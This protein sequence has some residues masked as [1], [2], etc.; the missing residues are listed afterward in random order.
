[1]IE[2]ELCGDVQIYRASPDPLHYSMHGGGIPSGVQ[3]YAMTLS[4]APVEATF[5]PEAFGNIWVDD[6]NPS[7]KAM[8]RNRGREPRKV[9]LSLET[10]S[11]DGREKT[12][13]KQ[14]FELHGGESVTTRFDLA[15]RR[16]GWHDVVLKYG[17]QVHRRSLVI[18]RR[19]EQTPRPFDTRG[20]MFGIWSPGR[21]HYTLSPYDTFRLAGPLGIE[22]ISH[23][24]S[25]LAEPEI[26]ALPFGLKNFEVAKIGSRPR[27][28]DVP[29]LAEKLRDARIA[30]S[31]VSEP[32]FQYLFAEPGGIGSIG[33]LPEFYGEP[34][35]QRTPQEEER[36]VDFKRMVTNFSHHFRAQYP[37]K[38]IL[39][40]WGNP[41]FAIP[42]LQDPATREAFD[43]VGF[44]TAFFD[45]LPEMQAHQCS[46]H[47]MMLQFNHY[48]YTYRK[49]PPLVVTVEGPCLG[50]VK[51]GALT[52]DQ[53]AAHLPRA[54]LTLMPYGI[55]RFFASVSGGPENCS[56]WGEQ[57]YGGGAFT[58]VTLDPYPA[59]ATQGTLIRHL[60]HME[61]VKAVPTGS[62]STFCYQFKD[63][64][65]NSLLH[66]LW[67]IRGRR[68]VKMSK[69]E[70][71]DSMDNL[72]SG[73]LVLDQLPVYVYGCDGTLE[74]GEPDHRD[75]QLA[76]DRVELGA[77]AD[78]FARQTQE[79]DAEY[80]NAFPGDIRRFPAAMQLERVADGL[81]VT[82]PAQPVDRGLMPFF[83]TLHPG[84]PVVIPGKAQYLTVEV[85]AASDW[86][87]IVYVLR[88][89][90]DER[91]IS[92]GT[93]DTYN[94]DDTPNAS[95][96]NFDGRRLVRFE[97]PANL[98]WDNYREM[99]STWWGAYDG[100][101][102]VD[103]PLAIEKIIIER[104]PQAIYGNR[105]EPTDP[106]PVV[107]GKLYA[108]YADEALTREAP[109]L[110]MPPP[111]AVAKPYNPIRELAA[112]AILP[113]GAIEKVTEPEHYYDGTRGHFYF[114]ELP[115]AVKYDIYLSLSPDGANAIK[116]GNGLK[117]SGALV[118]GFLAG[119]DFYAFLIYYDKAEQHSRP[120]APFKL[121]LEDKFAN[122]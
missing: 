122:K 108:E 35:L 117:E 8:L 70:A 38:K 92:V 18:L 43:G 114:K 62:L 44:D 101:K 10:A 103:L 75:A 23:N 39:M 68:P 53:H 29:D 33:A 87:R 32:V 115:D 22:S 104:R 20:F 41:L 4:E 57:H 6:M 21:T 52:V 47:A 74:L 98:P 71:Y 48:W 97:L 110:A 17:D 9:E 28:H 88:D 61:F 107:F 5:D 11:Y 16:Y 63:A 99:G 116:L 112:S 100:D 7:Y 111:P 45:R 121:R 72:I 105:L 120:S 94:N 24:G 79:A 51:P 40:P 106:A 49:E 95:Y 50:G 102:V 19:R 67:T 3:V 64:R 37:G 60:R 14:Q 58:R 46:L 31:T 73:D 65:D 42:F 66:I 83:T 36:L 15:L 80:R 1:M 54:M 69:T 2:I 12:S 27:A 78:L 90:K 59:Y 91:W 84:E 85:T 25:M 56:Y 77:V 89:A 96:F 93:Q 118:Q 81:A 76:T 119:T 26:A 109:R 55:N 34:P 86:G 13:Q 113:A 82:L 30:P